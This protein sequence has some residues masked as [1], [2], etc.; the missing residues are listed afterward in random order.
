MR[1]ILEGCDGTSFG[2]FSNS[3]RDLS[4]KFSTES[5][6]KRFTSGGKIWS[7]WH[8]RGDFLQSGACP[9]WLPP[10]SGPQRRKLVFLP[11]SILFGDELALGSRHFQ[12]NMLH[13]SL[14]G[15]DRVL[16]SFSRSQPLISRSM[17]SFRGWCRIWRLQQQG[18][19]TL[20]HLGYF[21][22]E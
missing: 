15:W 22:V 21:F 18:T 9:G 20:Q 7:Y 12:M 4:G 6:R 19:S 16:F 2:P 8:L 3:R 13:L 11:S 10:S 1:L 14:L 17:G 5:W